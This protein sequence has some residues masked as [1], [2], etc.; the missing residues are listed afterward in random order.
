MT[1]SKTHKRIMSLFI[2]LVSMGV[3]F[4]GSAAAAGEVDGVTL[5]AQEG[6]NPDL[7]AEDKIRF[8]VSEYLRIDDG[9]SYLADDA[10][11]KGAATTFVLKL[12]RLLVTVIS[13][14]A[15]LFLIAGG[16]VLM[17]SHGN[18]QMQQKG[19]QIILYS[20]I[21]LVVAFLSLII[22]TYVQSLFYVK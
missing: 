4:I 10:Q 8:D 6:Q 1:I 18:S 14:F 11:Q 16:I 13:S 12:I 7:S 5:L 20:I 22:V 15:L 9:Q 3:F 21:G 19:K 17:V 2:L